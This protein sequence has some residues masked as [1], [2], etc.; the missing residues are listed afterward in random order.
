LTFDVQLFNTIKRKLPVN[1][2]IVP[3]D[4]VFSLFAQARL[5]CMI[6][7]FRNGTLSAINLKIINNN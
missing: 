4:K 6:D 2:S 7:I 1:S 5:F 3:A